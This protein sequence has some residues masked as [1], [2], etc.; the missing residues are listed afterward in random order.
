MKGV[1]AILKIILEIIIK[2]YIIKKLKEI[3]N[4]KQRIR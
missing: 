2:K 3:N 4:G 1:V